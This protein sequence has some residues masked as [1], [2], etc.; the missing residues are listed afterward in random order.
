[1]PGTVTPQEAAA[2]GLSRSGLY[3]AV[4]AGRYERIARG[5]YVPADAQA[6]DW[7]RIEAVQRRPEATVCLTSALAHHHLTDVIPDE[8]DLAIRRGAR[9][10]ASTAAIAWHHFDNDT[11]D[12]GRD[13]TPIPGTDLIIG[14][15][16]P[17][18]SIAD[19]FRLR[20]LV[21]YELS[22]DALKEWLSQGGKPADLI[23]LA[24]ELPRA[25]GPLLRALDM[26]A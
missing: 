19:A 16:S 5:I 21:G 11:F 1:M 9:T 13:E 17:E 10:P 6:T 12:V 15:Y 4:Q 24:S 3:R 18:R 7:D 26:L 25:K 23:A 14:V 22:R 20:G 8:L 2:V